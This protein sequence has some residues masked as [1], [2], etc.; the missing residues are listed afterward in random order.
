MTD[1]AGTITYLHISDLHFGNPDKFGREQVLG[2][3]LEIVKAN[4]EG[5]W[6]PDFIVC[7][8]DIAWTG[9]ETEYNEL[10]KPFFDDLLKAV[11]LKNHSTIFIVPGNHD[12]NETV[13]RPPKITITNMQQSRDFF[14]KADKDRML[15]RSLRH[16]Q[17]YC[18]FLRDYTGRCFDAQNYYLCEVFKVRELPIGIMGL[19]SAWLS[20]TI[21]DRQGEIIEEKGSLVLGMRCIERA[22]AKLKELEN[23]VG[24]TVLRIVM[25]HHPLSYFRSFED[26]RIRNYLAMHADLALQG[27][28]DEPDSYPIPDPSGQTDKTCLVIQA[29]AAYEN[30][31]WPNRVYFARCSISTDTIRVTANPFMYSG[32]PLTP[33]VPDTIAFASA[34]KDS[35]QNPYW[36]IGTGKKKEGATVLMPSLESVGQVMVQYARQVEHSLRS[37]SYRPW[38]RYYVIPLGLKH[39]EWDATNLDVVVGGRFNTLS[40]ALQQQ[41]HWVLLGGAGSG[42]TAMLE[43]LVVDHN[44]KIWPILI[45]PSHVAVDPTSLIQQ[46]LGSYKLQAK[47]EDITRGLRE[48]RFCLLVDGLEERNDRERGWV[49]QLCSDHP[50]LPAIVA[51]RDTFYI[52]LPATERLPDHF[53]LLEI[54]LVSGE[55]IESYLLSRLG[56]EEGQRCAEIIHSKH[57]EQVFATPL[58]LD[59]FCRRHQPGQPVPESKFALLD[60]F[61]NSFFSEWE[62]LHGHREDIIIKEEILVRIAGFL[63]DRGSYFAPLAQFQRKLRDIWEDIQRRHPSLQKEQYPYYSLLEEGLIAQR[64]GQASFAESLHRDFFLLK[65]KYQTAARTWSE[66]KQLAE[67]CLSLDFRAEATELYK[68]AAFDPQASASCRIAAALCCKSQ[69]DYKTA[70]ELFQLEQAYGNPVGYQAHA[71]MLKEEGRFKEAEAQFQKGVEADPTDAPLHQAY[72]IMLREQGRFE[73]AEAQFQKGVEADPTHAHSHQAYAIMLKEQGRFEEAEAQFQKGLKGD[74]THAHLYQAYAIM[75]KEQGRFEEAEA[76]FQKGLKADPTHAH[77]YQAY[78]IMLKEQGRFEEAE[79]QFQKGLK[80]DPTHVPLYQAYAMMLKERGRFED[81]RLLWD[82]IIRIQPDNLEYRLDYLCLLFYCLDALR[83]ADEVTAELLTQGNPTKLK[84]NDRNYLKLTARLIDWRH[85]MLAGNAKAR[86]DTQSHYQYAGRLIDHFNFK[87]GV[88][89]LNKLLEQEPRHADAHW[90]LAYTLTAHNEMEEG[91]GHAKLAVSLDSE[92]PKYHFQLAHSAIHA[93]EF[94]LAHSQ[95]DWLLKRSPGNTNYLRT[96]GFAFRKAAQ[97]DKAEDAYWIAV[98]AAEVPEDRARTLK[99]LAQLMME[100]GDYQQWDVAWQLIERAW[101]LHL[102]DPAIFGTRKQLGEKLGRS[103]RIDNPYQ[104]IRDRLEPGDP[105]S[106]QVYRIDKTSGVQVYYYGVPGSLSW[107]EDSDKLRIGERIDNVLVQG[108]NGESKL[109]L[110]WPRATE[111]RRRIQAEARG[112]QL[113]KIQQVN[114]EPGQHIDAVVSNFQSYGVF[115]DYQGVKGLIHRSTMP[116]PQVFDPK[117]FPIGRGE[118]IRCRV[119][120][121]QPDGNVRLVWE[122]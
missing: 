35:D 8:G 40:D 60:N 43:Q 53:G 23:E 91:L 107:I 21:R 47:A 11:G 25:F 62:Y 14:E 75:L 85:S 29:G 59:D 118:S 34:A 106:V 69:Q 50:E 108:I 70:E 116:N 99:N 15:E 66:K 100:R 96:R 4:A 39:L 73:E 3:L 48:Q 71:I 104:S 80:A 76:Q 84:T 17:G 105:I 121:I 26:S 90:R 12:V 103:T 13:T 89:E 65:G 63:F 86:Q 112:Q 33:W 41:P 37:R 93:G 2:S 6:R 51:S 64:A 79:A 28:K 92:Q 81:A 55:Y 38:R 94:D 58:F 30:D 54:E 110:S 113:K 44:E 88:E 117:T 119:L 77:L 67:I 61:F 49:R 10:A 1:Q 19:N 24:R 102:S 120:S 22:F 42:K 36:D 101:A 95:V 68:D 32:D 109:Q 27:H 83:E 87:R 7:T 56:T 16:L 46:V 115:V 122:E 9:V 78:A 52:D 31:R 114:L 82:E 98:D 111:Q 74:P 20:R 18:E 97:W 57:L 45:Q 72:A 5:E